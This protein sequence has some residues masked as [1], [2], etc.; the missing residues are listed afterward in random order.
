MSILLMRGSASADWINVTQAPYFVRPNDSVSCERAIQSAIDTAYSKGGGF[1]YIPKGYYL[2]SAKIIVK[3]NVS[4]LGDGE[5]SELR[6]KDGTS[7][8]NFGPYPRMIELEQKTSLE[9][10]YFN[11]NKASSSPPAIWGILA[12]GPGLGYVQIRNCRVSNFKLAAVV[13]ANTEYFTLDNNIISDNDR[14]AFYGSGNYMT[15]TNNVIKNNIEDYGIAIETNEAYSA[16]HHDIL[17]SGNV[18]ENCKVGVGLSQKYDDKTPVG[19]RYG[20]TKT[21][22]YNNRISNTYENGIFIGDASPNDIP[23]EYSAN[24]ILVDG[25]ILYDCGGCNQLVGAGIVCSRSYKIT[26]SNNTIDRSN[27]EV[28]TKWGI[29]ISNSDTISLS[30]NNVSRAQQHDIFVINGKFISI[31]YNTIKDALSAGLY[32]I[33][34][35]HVT[36][37]GNNVKSNTTAMMFES[38]SNFVIFDNSFS[39]NKHIIYP[40][41]SWPEFSQPSKST[42]LSLNNYIGN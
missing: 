12:Y 34:S 19:Y 23:K 4:L 15:I 14:D 24:G 2:I 32:F 1:V 18:I 21:V 33:N 37:I 9:K 8:S 36:M 39:L 16:P 30:N 25:N 10:L 35:T 11:G 27:S 13:V 31:V 3:E 42:E 20:P 7:L 26:I 41:I 29:I 17:I 40:A 22:I 6:V 5:L 38:G 28:H